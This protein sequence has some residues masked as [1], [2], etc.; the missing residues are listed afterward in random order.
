MPL[1]ILTQHITSDASLLKSSALAWRHT[2]SNS[3]TRNYCCLACEWTLSF[4]DTLIALYLLTFK[5]TDTLK[6]V[7][8]FAIVAIGKFTVLRAL[9]MLSPEPLFG[10]LT[11]TPQPYGDRAFQLPLC[12]SGTVF[13]SISHLLRHFPSS[14]LAWRHTSSNSVTRNYCCRHAVL[15][16]VGSMY[17]WTLPCVS[18]LVPSVLHLSHGFHCSPTLNRQPYEGMLPLRS[19]WRK[20]SNMTVGQCSLIYLAHHR[21]DWHPWSRCG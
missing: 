18:S 15:T 8:A 7:P 3:V 20:S 13:C 10:L 9:Y 4:M 14:A 12:R 6:T 19:W 5:H 17:S 11:Y 2:S 1:K 16:Q 21:Y